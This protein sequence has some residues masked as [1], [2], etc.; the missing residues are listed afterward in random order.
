M[1]VSQ[2]N[3]C[4]QK[5]WD[6]IGSFFFCFFPF[7]VRVPSLIILYFFGCPNGNWLIFFSVS[8][9]QLIMGPSHLRTNDEQ[10]IN[11]LLPAILI[12]YDRSAVE[13]WDKILIPLIAGRF[14]E[15]CG[16]SRSF[17]ERYRCLLVGWNSWNVAARWRC[18]W[19]SGLFLLILSRLSGGENGDHV[20]IPSMRNFKVEL[21]ERSLTIPVI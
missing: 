17:P 6:R 12:V 10:I 15:I 9:S 8:T 20:C 7:F 19:C 18:Q 11:W 2:W 13:E 16:V 5:F 3:R 1:S 4:F 21:T 14:V